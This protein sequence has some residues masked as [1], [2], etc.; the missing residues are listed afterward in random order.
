MAMDKN[1]ERSDPDNE[2]RDHLAQEEL[3][4]H[5]EIER[6]TTQHAERLREIETDRWRQSERIEALEAQNAELQTDFLKHLRALNQ[7][8][9]DAR[10]AG[11]IATA[12]QEAQRQR[13]L[14]E[15]LQTKDR[16]ASDAQEQR[17]DAARE[18]EAM[19]RELSQLRREA[20][21]ELETQRQQNLTTFSEL[22]RAK[23]SLLELQRAHTQELR[24][25]ERELRERAERHAEELRAAE[26]AHA[27]QL[28]R[29]RDARAAEQQRLRDEFAEL[30]RRG[31]E[32]DRLAEQLRGEREA[33]VGDASAARAREAE[34]ALRLEREA[35][36]TAELET[37]LDQLRGAALDAAATRPAP[38]A[39]AVQPPAVQPVDP[40]LYGELAKLRQTNQLLERDLGR[41]R[42]AASMLEGKLAK[43]K[44]TLSFRLGYLLIHNP[45]S[46]D[47]IRRLPRELF[48]LN[49]EARRRRE[50]RYGGKQPVSRQSPARETLVREFVEQVEALLHREGSDSA[51]QLITFG[52]A[53]DHQRAAA[54]THVAKLLKTSDPA[55]AKLWA[56]RAHELEPLPF[57]AKWL[58][59]LTYETGEIARPARLLDLL[60]SDFALK[61]SEK[62]RVAEIQG[63]ARLQTRLL[64]L[65]SPQPSTQSAVPSSVLYVAASALPFHVSGYTIRTHAIL[66]ALSGAGIGVTAALRPGYPGDRGIERAGEPP[67]HLVDGVR[68]HHVAGPHVR[69]TGL[70]HYVEG[71]ATAL[72]ELARR[73]RPQ[74]IHAASN[75][76]NAL[77][78]LV[79]ARR[80]GIPFVYEVRGMWELSAATRHIDWERSER[81]ALERD[82]ETLVA[83]HADAVL[84]LTEAL[85]QE[86]ALRGVGRERI[87]VVPN[88]VDPSLFSPRR[89]HPE[90]M[91]RFGL[92]PQQFMLVYA[93]SLLHYE[94]LDDLVR[95]V[96]T[97]AQSG[98]DAMLV[99]AGEGEA[100]ESLERLAGELGVERR[101]KLVGRV[102]HGQIADLWSL[103]DVAAFPR[104]PFRVC[105]LVSPLK[106][107]E[108]MA[109]GI[110]VVVSDVAALREMVRDDETGLV[111]RA[112]DATSLAQKLLQ[113]ANDPATRQR[114]GRAA[115]EAVL[116]ERTWASVAER[117]TGAYRKLAERELEPGIV[118]L[119]P[120]RTS[121]TNEEKASF[122]ANLERAFAK[123]GATAARALARRQAAGRS[124][125]FEAFCLLKAATACQ[126]G[127][128]NE[129]SLELARAALALDDN[130]STLRGAARLLYTNG[131]VDAAHAA[132]ERWEQT[133]GPLSGRDDELAREVR[134]RKSLLEQLASERAG[135]ALESIPGKSV[136]ILHF[137]LPYT[138]V[139]Y[140]TRSHGLLAGVR[141]A[142]YDVKAYT[143][144][145]FPQDFKPEL[146]GQSL[147]E[148]D[149]VD[150][151]EYRR[152]FAG[153]RR[154]M[155]E[156][157]YLL[158]SA[159]AYEQVLRAERPEVVHAASNYV[160][161]LPALLAAR[162]LGLPFIYEI[163]GFWEIT[164]S[165][166]DSEFENS[167]RF[168][169]MRHHE[170][171]V[172]RE[173]DRIFTLTS[174]MKDELV[175]R[176]VDA[177]KIDLVH[178]G[179]DP[180]RFQPLVRDSELAARLD[181]PVGV[182][183]IGYV[184]SFVDYEG[185]DDLVRAAGIL[186][187]RRLD[188]RLLLVGD[189]ATLEAVQRLVEAEQLSDRTRLTGRVRHDEVD[190]YYS[191]VDICPFPRKPWEVCEMVSPL[192]PFEA[193]AMNKVVI[194]SS[195]HALSEIVRD[196]ETGLVFQKGSPEALARGL[197]RLIAEPALRERLQATAREWVLAQRTWQSAGR[198]VVEGY[199]K[200]KEGN[201]RQ[202]KIA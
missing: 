54:L 74:V 32:Y 102:D 123:G 69:R 3:D 86:L 66:K 23:D 36:R 43:S 19:L 161:A 61:P 42:Q 33:L 96:A 174:A 149:V 201:L 133:S 37:Q 88:A 97:L 49:Q 103:A 82:L 11:Q 154:G 91:L 53:D 46:W 16:L 93:G 39:P 63:L 193:M 65:P 106:P 13:L 81:F 10:Q 184:G 76:V 98:I 165:S 163:R 112:G 92:K 172:A 183:V 104:K 80:L 129:G 22:S 115:R 182:P 117:M 90:L 199:R 138:S 45:K 100:K 179:V 70:D 167:A 157:E 20:A 160:T 135:T 152:L 132:L 87:T 176:G 31:A 9:S 72:V 109:M 50:R 200:V 4:A 114:L 196:G 89:K 111:H 151:I 180:E 56:E 73:V 181:L 1:A 137:S 166:R 2:L 99:L 171:L 84:T 155:T 105:E 38:P 128:D 24:Q 144:P 139:G 153:G 141:A 188:F 6:L 125:R 64:P 131:E 150:G 12:A 186:A 169:M 52:A 18:H 5:A 101:I 159:A 118:V 77:P 8:L 120:G 130:V 21:A 121:L 85:A 177:D 142:G 187:R 17:K 14:D 122:E 178:N 173:A 124:P 164:R 28:A 40:K 170:N 51:E 71:A 140:A 75:H 44:D 27:E 134:G 35:A 147:P 30:M 126:R 119:P 113:L 185:L 79:A 198:V 94:G 148:L 34:L 158:S 67:E 156:S 41:S 26:R 95:A 162:R 143:R 197:E 107:L 58:A 127:S 189:G 192:K 175:R 190:K 59:F 78:A 108:P 29:E 145:G 146:E 62:A 116:R 68:Y 7:E 15:L 55:R 47:G 195:T 57:R 48:E 194:V 60:P 25:L 110:P 202:R 136:N 168:A 83:Q 191:L